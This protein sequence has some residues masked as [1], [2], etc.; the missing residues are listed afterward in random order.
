VYLA[1]LEV[2][3]VDEVVRAGRRPGAREA[4]HSSV[5]RCCF[6]TTIFTKESRQ[7]RSHTRR[8][9]SLARAA[10]RRA[11]RGD[12]PTSGRRIRWRPSALEMAP[13]AACPPGT[14]S[15]PPAP[16]HPP[17]PAATA[18]RQPFSSLPSPK[19]AP[20]LTHS[21]LTATTTKEQRGRLCTM[22]SRQAQHQFRPSQ[23]EGKGAGGKERHAESGEQR[24]GR[25]TPLTVAASVLQLL[26][27][28]AGAW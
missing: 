4:L 19:L 23:R 21:F 28:A 3:E 10:M 25:R 16:A 5:S 14:A 7:K 2:V 17:H 13:A 27:A 24:W 15:P 26:G 18:Y 1:A 12:G 20:Q 9:T 8:M 22:S 11:Q 6:S